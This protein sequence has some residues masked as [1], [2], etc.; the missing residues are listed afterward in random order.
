MNAALDPQ[1][2]PYS[3]LNVR[4]DASDEDIKRAYKYVPSIML[5][6]DRRRL[7]PSRSRPARSVARRATVTP[8]H[9]LASRAF[10]NNGG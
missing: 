4:R 5:A 6:C 2:D 9:V 1:A 10:I 8:S 7:P 3:V